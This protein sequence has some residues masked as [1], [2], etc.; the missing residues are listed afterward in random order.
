MT[1]EAK[2]KY[3]QLSNEEL[4]KISDRFDQEFITDK[5]VPL[6]AALQ[7]AHREARSAPDPTPGPTKEK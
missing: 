7:K 1:D 6:D 4:D 2:N 3:S 5:S